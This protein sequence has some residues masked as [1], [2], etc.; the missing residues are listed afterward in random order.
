MEA[1]KYDENQSAARQMGRNA[2]WTN[3]DDQSKGLN[4]RAIYVAGGEGWDVEEGLDK[5]FHSWLGGAP[6]GDLVRVQRSPR[7][8]GDWLSKNENK[9][10]DR[11]FR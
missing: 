5:T 2:G 3:W 1:I 6:S 4:G 11:M 9:K 8:G 10:F 7:V